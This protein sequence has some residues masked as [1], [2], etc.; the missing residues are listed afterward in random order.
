VRGTDRDPVQDWPRPL[1]VHPSAPVLVVALLVLTGWVLLV[2][3]DLLRLA[4]TEG[5]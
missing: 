5:W 1:R 3:V 4:G 2:T